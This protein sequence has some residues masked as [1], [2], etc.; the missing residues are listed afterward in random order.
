MVVTTYVTV[1][2]N[3]IASNLKHGTNR[4][5]VRVSLGKYGKPRHVRKFTAEGKITVRSGPPLP[6]GARVWLEVQ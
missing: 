5:A 4:P 3:I 6:W 1:C 2:K